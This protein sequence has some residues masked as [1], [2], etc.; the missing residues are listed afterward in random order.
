MLIIV[1]VTSIVISGSILILAIFLLC[2]SRLW[3]F[4]FPKQIC[5][6]IR[7]VFLLC[8]LLLLLLF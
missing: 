8:W 5:I 2:F 1:I 4:F 6:S 7:K 3:K